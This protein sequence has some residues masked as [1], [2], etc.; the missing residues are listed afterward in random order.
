VKEIEIAIRAKLLHQPDE[1][2]LLL[3]LVIRPKGMPLLRLSVH[4]DHAKEVDKAPL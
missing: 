2:L 3:T 1:H 4:D